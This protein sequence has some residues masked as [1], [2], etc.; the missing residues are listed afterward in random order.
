M[1]VGA[2]VWRKAASFLRLGAWLQL[3]FLPTWLLLG[4]ARLVILTVSFR[5]LAP[6]LGTANGPHALVPL[7]TTAQRTRAVQIG[8]V[9]RLAAGYTPWVSNCFPQAVVAR[10]LL[11]L[12]GIPY[13]VYFGLSRDAQTG[14]MLAHAWVAAGPVC[15]AGGYSFNEYTVVGCFVP[16]HLLPSAASPT[17]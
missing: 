8:R 1:R 16:A 12:H 17:R 6:R 7:I 11:G 10:L 13:A 4:L 14:A 5:R 15:V 3:W 2:A 9:V